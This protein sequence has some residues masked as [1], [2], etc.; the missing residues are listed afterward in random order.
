LEQKSRRRAA[1]EKTATDKRLKRIAERRFFK[2]K[3]QKTIEI[4][5]S[6]FIDESYPMN[7]ILPKLAALCSSFTHYWR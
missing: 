4:F 1:N 7:I 6:K 2:K 5:S 3:L